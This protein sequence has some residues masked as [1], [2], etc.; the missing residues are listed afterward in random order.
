MA[1]QSPTEEF[2]RLAIRM[3][4]LA[5]PADSHEI[6]V[7]DGVR[8]VLGRC[9][10]GLLV[11]RDQLLGGSW[12]LAHHD[13][14]L[15]LPGAW[16]TIDE[17]LL[18]AYRIA[19]G[20][21]LRRPWDQI[22]G[23][24]DGRELARR[25][26]ALQ[27]DATAPLPPRREEPTMPEV[28]QSSR[29]WVSGRL[30]SQRM[31]WMREAREWS[32]RELADQLGWTQSKVSRYEARPSQGVSVATAQEIALG[33]G[34]TLEELLQDCGLP[35]T[36][37]PIAPEIAP[38]TPVPAQSE[39]ALEPTPAQPEASEGRA[40]VT[41]ITVLSG[42]N[43]HGNGHHAEPAETEEPGDIHEAA[44]APEEELPPGV[45]RTVRATPGP[46]P[47]AAQA[48][49]MTL[50]LMQALQECLAALLRAGE[51]EGALV[52]GASETLRLGYNLGRATSLAQ[53][54]EGLTRDPQEA[55]HG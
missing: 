13:S 33:F 53:R 19:E 34:L 4:Q 11:H 41:G 29:E 25:C 51:T 49:E 16:E 54:L 42:S 5:T 18:A 17:A 46:R 48:W 45:A 21:E 52:L 14:G 20:L 1:I 50:P 30:L 7:E 31:R 44:A 55:C 22:R 3:R 8:K 9:W 47:Q 27:H 40:G 24:P 12:L 23:T 38:A 26:R 39:P 35:E 32:Q 10:N 15:A 6:Q 28:I 37:P 43:G 36:A 2:A